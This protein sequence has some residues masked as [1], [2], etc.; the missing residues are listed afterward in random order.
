[1]AAPALDD[2]TVAAFA[3]RMTETLNDAFLAFMVSIGHQ[4]GLFDTMAGLP[5]ATGEDSPGTTS[6]R[7]R[8]PRRGRRR[9]HGD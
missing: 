6:P 9:R 1:M 4:T 5:A 8:L 3:Q 7:K 2:S